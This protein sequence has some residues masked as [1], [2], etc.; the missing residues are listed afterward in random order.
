MKLSNKISIGYRF[1]N[2]GKV[3]RIF[4]ESD[5]NDKNVFILMKKGQNVGTISKFGNTWKCSPNGM[6]LE[7]D[8]LKIGNHID[9]YLKK[10]KDAMEKP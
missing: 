3:E 5:F 10:I 6:F 9:E 1:M 4:C 7:S 2:W 8:G